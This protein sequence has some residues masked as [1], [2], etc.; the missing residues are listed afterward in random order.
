LLGAAALAVAACSNANHGG[1]LPAGQTPPLGAK[2]A[3]LVKLSIK[4]PSRTHER[5]KHG[6]PA[7]VS[8]ATASLS[9]TVD[10]G[11]PVT[12][13]I[14]TSNPNCQVAGAIGYLQCSVSIP[15]TPGSHAFSFSTYDAQSQL[16]SANTSLTYVVQPGTNNQIPVT[17]GGVATSL[18]IVL[19]VA[20]QL[21]GNPFGGLSL[22]GPNPISVSVLPVDADG[23]YIIGPGAPQP[24]LSVDGA[25]LTTPAPSA[26]NL[27][28]VSNT[29]PEILPTAPTTT[30]IVVSATPVPHSGG[31]TVSASQA[32]NL[33]QPWIYVANQQPSGGN[34]TSFDFLGNVTLAGEFPG[35]SSPT[36]IAVNPATN[37]FAVSGANGVALYYFPGSVTVPNAFPNTTSP[38]GVAF[39]S[40]L[41]YVV[42][43]AASIT[44]YNA[45]GSQVTPAGSFTLPGA[46]TA[47]AVDDSDDEYVA[48]GTS[49]VAAYVDGILIS[50]Q[51]GPWF[52]GV[53]NAAG[54]AFD[55]YLDD[56]YV[57]DRAAKTV[58]AFN[59]DGVSI[60]LTG[61]F[62]GLT[63]PTA[64]TYDAVQDRLYVID[65]DTGKILAFDP[66][67]H[68]LGSLAFA[69]LDHPSAMVVIP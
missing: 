63:D 13:T 49:G 18:A 30:S 57:V 51:G 6:R 38:V 31:S 9:Y 10:A 25:T 62:P 21:A 17:L 48:C 22:Y 5:H 69:G 66:Q 24:T 16:L 8:P 33:L 52:P 59:Q 42:A 3:A 4:V 58:L 60:P 46:P 54:I 2:H 14:A 26:P 64:I 20:P 15:L 36:G 7:Y 68:A 29:T 50:N 28:T 37:Q 43:N 27:W 61:T 53:Q 40:V 1:A 45:S 12:V 56:V 47:I 41:G 34:V 23:N 55:S 32:L 19:P 44:M 35:V 11:S 39:S 65:N 67:G